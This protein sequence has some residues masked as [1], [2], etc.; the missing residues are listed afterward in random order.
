MLIILFFR[1]P[2]IDVLRY[3]DEIQLCHLEPDSLTSEIA[4]DEVTNFNEACKELV[5]KKP[6]NLCCHQSPSSMSQINGSS[7]FS[8]L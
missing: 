4:N 3:F 7:S 1:I 8:N 5:D 6:S 2:F